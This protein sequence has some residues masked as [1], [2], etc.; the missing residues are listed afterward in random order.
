MRYDC[1]FYF[2]YYCTS[3]PSCYSF[4]LPVF[5]Y[6]SFENKD[7]INI[8]LV[9]FFTD[10]KKKVHQS[11]WLTPAFYWSSPSFLQWISLSFSLIGALQWKYTIT[12]CKY[13]VCLYY[14]INLKDIFKKNC[15]CTSEKQF[16]VCQ[17][18]GS[19]VFWFALSA[20]INFISSSNRLLFSDKPL[21]ILYVH[22]IVFARYQTAHRQS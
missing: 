21:V 4:T 17:L 7:K 11:V 19:S 10:G 14:L 15:K 8:S 13:I 12:L 16:S 3:S 1:C 22:C 18:I 2:Y 20:S 9:L 5:N 6:S